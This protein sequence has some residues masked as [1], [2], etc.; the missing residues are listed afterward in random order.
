MSAISRVACRICRPSRAPRCPRRPAARAAPGLAAAV[1]QVAVVA[2]VAV[3]HSKPGRVVMQRFLSFSIAVLLVSACQSAPGSGTTAARM[4]SGPPMWISEPA[5]T[6]ADL[7]QRL[8][9]IADD[10]MMGRE[11]GSLGAFKASA[12]VASQFRRLGLE[13]AGASG[14]YFQN[15]PF[16]DIKVDSTSRLVTSG[17]TTLQLGTDFLPVS[18][19]VLPRVLDHSAVVYAGSVGDSA[20]LMTPAAGDVAGKFVVLDVPP[21]FDRRTLGNY[22]GRYREAL[23]VGIIALDQLGSEQIARVVEGRPVADTAHNPR[24]I[25]VVWLSRRAGT[26]ILGKEP[27]AV[28]PG[29]ATGTAVSGHYDFLRTP[30][31]YPARNVVGILR[32]NDSTLRGEY[33]SLTAHH[34][35]VGF[36]HHPVDHD[37]LRAFNRVVRPMGAD[38]PNR[39]ATDSEWVKIRKNLDSLR[40]IRPPRPDSIR[41]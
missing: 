30:V 16:W 8:Y 25:A 12:Y 41:N 28:A 20:H 29:T 26:A 9:L 13:P 4:T 17:G 33:V 19:A 23:T 38:S 32:G 14:T 2:V 11:T 18:F 24:A 36:D 31:A 5:I 7:R 10:S 39:P 6:A 22:L 27:A 35:H 21:G 40:A 1:D 15:V 37:S 34:D 3:A